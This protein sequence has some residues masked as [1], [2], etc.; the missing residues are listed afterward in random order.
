MA[1][2]ARRERLALRNQAIHRGESAQPF[3]IELTDAAADR[4][5]K[6][7]C[8][9]GT[10]TLLSNLV[11]KRTWRERLVTWRTD[12]LARAF[13]ASPDLQNCGIAFIGRR[14]E[15]VAGKLDQLR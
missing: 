7:C 10:D 2:R 6:H 5:R 3:A 4:D 9:A 11:Q 8:E 12:A 13:R 15:R 14:A 1:R